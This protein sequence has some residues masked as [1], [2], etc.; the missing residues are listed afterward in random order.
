MNDLLSVVG[1]ISKKIAP[2]FLSGRSAYFH[3]DKNNCA[4]EVHFD[5]DKTDVSG[6]VGSAG[7]NLTSRELS[8]FMSCIKQIS[9]THPMAKTCKIEIATGLEFSKDSYPIFPRMAFQNFAIGK[10][11]EKDEAIVQDLEDTYGALVEISK[12]VDQFRR[13]DRSLNSLD[14]LWEKAISSLDRNEKGKL[15]E[16]IFVLLLSRDENFAITERNLRTESEELDIVVENKGVSQFY[17]QL[18]CPIILFECKNW[19]SKIGAKEIRDFAQKI[20]NRPK[21]LCTLGILATTSQLTSDASAELLGYRGKD[22]LIGVLERNDI[23]SVLRERIP[24][25]LYLKD[26]IRKSGMR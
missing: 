8:D 9:R 20:Q 15:L 7:L 16:E 21:L 23:E 19:S 22:F 11:N 17:F 14:N 10:S 12:I 4:L 6:Y 2:P 24:F 3:F 13:K 26:V 25:G 5:D 1:K 18:R